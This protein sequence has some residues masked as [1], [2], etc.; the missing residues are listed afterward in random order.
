M[1]CYNGRKFIDDHTV[2]WKG[3][4]ISFLKLYV[5]YPALEN[6]PNPS[7]Y[8][9]GLWGRGRL[10]QNHTSLSRDTAGEKGRYKAGIWRTLLV[11][12]TYFYSVQHSSVWS[13]SAVRIL[14][15]FLFQQ[16]SS[17][18][19]GFPFSHSEVCHCRMQNIL[20]R[21]QRFR[22]SIVYFIKWY[23]TRNSISF[24]IEKTSSYSEN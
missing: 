1:M 23:Q 7:H 3:A 19:M 4:S 5:A 18:H 9:L 15:F 21:S 12:E 13:K 10:G 16:S 24:G 14:A 22:Q 2:F 17:C 6:Y 8:S 11:G 20:L